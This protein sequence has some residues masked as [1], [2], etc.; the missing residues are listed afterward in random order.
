[1]EVTQA[2][3]N[4]SAPAGTFSLA[5]QVTASNADAVAS[6][7]ATA[8]LANN[9][10]E[11]GVSA[12]GVPAIYDCVLARVVIGV[13][14]PL[15]A[16]SLD[17]DIEGGLLRVFNGSAQWHMQ[18]ATFSVGSGVALINVRCSRVWER[19]ERRRKVE[20]SRFCEGRRVSVHAQGMRRWC[21]CAW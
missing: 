1:M 11:V 4:A 17:V 3:F 21:F 6:V 10:I 18:N 13:P 8:T 2:P 16:L 9:S 5:V 20:C 19:C 7:H 15:S 14:V 12:R